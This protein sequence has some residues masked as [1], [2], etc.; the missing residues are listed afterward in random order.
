MTGQKPEGY[1]A[2]DAVY[3]NPDPTGPIILQVNG[4]PEPIFKA[5]KG[6]PKDKLADINL[7][8]DKNKISKE[9]GKLEKIELKTFG[10]HYQTL[11]KDPENFTEMSPDRLVWVVQAYYP[12]GFEH[13]KVGLIENAQVVG[14]YDAETGNLVSQSFRKL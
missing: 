12:G 14:I 11:G 2:D 5:N 10:E 13:P 7:K 4:N 3:L 6:T 8:I 9:N 1:T